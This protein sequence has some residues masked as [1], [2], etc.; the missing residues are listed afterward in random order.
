MEETKTDPEEP[1][2]GIV[3]LGVNDLEDTVTVLQF[4]LGLMQAEDV[5]QNYSSL[6]DVIV[7]RPLTK[8][9][10]RIH[11]RLSGFMKDYIYEKYQKEEKDAEEH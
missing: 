3:E 5:A 10:E 1:L 2:T 9:V 11:S 8:E 7:Y 6:N 4:V